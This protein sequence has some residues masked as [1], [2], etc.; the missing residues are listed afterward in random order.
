M[1][2]L[3][4]HPKL[5][6]RIRS[7]RDLKHSIYTLS[8]LYGEQKRVSSRFVTEHCL[9]T[10]ETVSYHT[11]K[12]AYLIIAIFHD[13]IEDLGLS[14]D[15]VKSISGQEGEMIARMVTTLSKR[16]DIKNRQ[17]R[18]TEYMNRLYRD[19][20]E[21]NRGVGLVKVSDRLSNLRDLEYLSPE[22][23]M[24]ISRQTLVFYLPIASR[25]GLINLSIRLMVLSLPH[26]GSERRLNSWK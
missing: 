10:A 13:I 18:N 21:G 20:S 3:R 2:D 11:N 14:F 12:P 15:D 7:S 19:I 23:R 4:K 9:E 24:A 6:R 25:L 8:E 1:I 26:I 17:V 5:E 16:T 22:K